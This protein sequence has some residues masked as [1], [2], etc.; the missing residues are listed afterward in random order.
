MLFVI[1]LIFVLVN[2]VAGFSL[3]DQLHRTY[4]VYDALPFTVSQA[5]S[6]GWRA[7]SNSSCVPGVGVEWNYSGTRSFDHPLTLGFTPAGQIASMGIWINGDVPAKLKKMGWWQMREMSPGKTVPYL[8]VTFR[9]T[10]HTCSSTTLSETLGDRLVVNGGAHSIPLTD[11]AA[12]KAKYTNGSCFETMGRHA[13]LDVETG[14][15]MSWQAENVSP[16]VPMYHN[17]EVA[18]I[19]FTVPEI[20]QGITSAHWWEPIPLP[21]YLQCKNMCDPA[22][23]FSG[24]SF[25]STMHI[26]FRDYKKIGCPGGC[27]ISCCN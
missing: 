1:A 5:K 14:P 11:Q 4:T 7:S 17:G 6:M 2:S 3:G 21:N 15:H 25:W 26:F 18:A 20:E 8:L 19:F 23:T 10:A 13:F 24:T 22:C 27:T 9:P 16:I 12:I